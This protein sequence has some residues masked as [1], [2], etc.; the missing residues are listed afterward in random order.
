MTEERKRTVFNV[1]AVVTLVG[2]AAFVAIVMVG[3]LRLK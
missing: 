3:A 1:V 2:F